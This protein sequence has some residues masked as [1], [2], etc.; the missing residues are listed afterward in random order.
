MMLPPSVRLAGAC[1]AL[2]ADISPRLAL[3]A[4]GR[5]SLGQEQPC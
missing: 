1:R 2:P 3:R 4:A 5:E